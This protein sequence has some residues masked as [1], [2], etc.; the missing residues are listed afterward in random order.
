MIRG[1]V[2]GKFMPVHKGHVAL[3]EYAC[4]QCDELIVSMSF[5]PLDPIPGDVR[6][7]WLKQSLTHLPKVKVFSIVDD[8]DNES[9]PLQERTKEWADFIVRTYPPIDVV[10]SSESYGE[11]F[12]QQLRARHLSFDPDRRKV[13]VSASLIRERPITY[14]DFIAEPARPFFVKKICVYGPESTG[15]S[16][17]TLRLAD[18]FQTTSV[19]EVAREMLTTNDFTVDDI[20]AIGRAHDERIT[21]Q[22]I[23][24]NRLLFCDTDVI[25]TQIYSRHYLGVIPEELY[26]IERKTRYSL[27]FLL[28][29][30]VPWVPDGL[31]DLGHRRVEMMQTFRDELIKRNIPFISVRG[32]FEAREKIMVA[33]VDKLIS[34]H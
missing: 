34:V 14:R 20:I 33:E 23:L 21:R 29:I 22:S 31:R 10:I 13:P 15:K 8:F 25:T 32:D 30:D 24:A 5:T 26:E 4:S 12:A 19:P 18:R 27:Y 28:D 7:S 3:I 16:T 2:I 17:L 1:L 6:F 11:P 9:L